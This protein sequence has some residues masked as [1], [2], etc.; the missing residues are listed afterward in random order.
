MYN[1]NAYAFLVSCKVASPIS[2]I[3]LET[4]GRVFYMVSYL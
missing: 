4:Y 2:N 3:K 1:G